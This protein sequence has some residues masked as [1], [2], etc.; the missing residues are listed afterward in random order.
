MQ[1]TVRRAAFAVAA[2]A[3]MFVAAPDAPAHAAAPTRVA[4]VDVQRAFNDLEEKAE[5][6]A[7]LR[8][9]A[10]EFESD[11]QQRV[12]TL[13]EAEADLEILVRDSP[14]Y[15]Q[16]LAKVERLAIELRVTQNHH[17]Q[18]LNR[19][20]A[21]QTEHLYRRLLDGIG[22]VAE[23]SDVD[24][25]L[26][27]ESTPDFTRADAQTKP[28]QIAALIQVRKVLWHRDALD[29]TDAVVNHLNARY[30]AVEQDR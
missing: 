28:E 8:S 5:L 23:T 4:V 22:Q 11:R 9:L 14:A 7:Q 12:K 10:T 6:E 3:F 21:V 29:L 1:F 16:Q 15:R 17:V 27:K 2:A 26:F 25:V 30:R 13:R 19:R 20:R 18:R 24:L